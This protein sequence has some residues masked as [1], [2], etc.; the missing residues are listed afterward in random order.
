MRIEVTQS[1]EQEHLVLIHFR[2][3]LTDGDHHD[4][5]LKMETAEAPTIDELLDKPFRPTHRVKATHPATGA[6]SETLIELDRNGYGWARQSMYDEDQPTHLFTGE[7]IPC[8][9]VVDVSGDI[10]YRGVRLDSA[11]IEE[12]E[13]KEIWH[14]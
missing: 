13:D 3:F 9:W 4:Y 7:P 5:M 11:V 10:H 12:I 2:V 6:H 8:N 1:V 14:E